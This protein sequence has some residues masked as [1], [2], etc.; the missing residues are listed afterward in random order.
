LEAR[1]TDRVGQAA[2][3]AAQLSEFAIHGGVGGSGKGALDG[4]FANFRDGLGG[5]ADLES[6]LLAV[7]SARGE[8]TFY[9]F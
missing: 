9:H 3:L 8:P 5:K 2:D 4:F 7:R 6:A 1:L